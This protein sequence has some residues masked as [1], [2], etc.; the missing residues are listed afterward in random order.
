MALN[1][2]II[3]EI[4]SH[5]WGDQQ[6]MHEVVVNGISC[7]VGTC[8]CLAPRRL[9]RTDRTRS[10]RVD[11]IC[12]SQANVEERTLQVSI[13]EKASISSTEV[14]VWLGGCTI[15]VEHPRIAWLNGSRDAGKL[16]EC[17]R[18]GFAGFKSLSVFSDCM[19]KAD[20]YAALVFFAAGGR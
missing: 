10:I 17:F 7:Q 19:E 12:T 11:A 6:L 1:E 5:I 14:L 13:L 8:R 2:N 15:P 9:C 4:L 3:F 16:T 20:F 18:E